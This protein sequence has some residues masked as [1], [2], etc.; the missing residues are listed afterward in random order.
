MLP[1][2]RKQRLPE[3]PKAE[4]EG[5]PKRHINEKVPQSV[6]GAMGIGATGIEPPVQ[7]GGEQRIPVHIMPS[8]HVAAWPFVE[9]LSIR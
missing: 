7:E 1:T 5:Y 2:R 6:R 4:D 8:G 9:G 3:H